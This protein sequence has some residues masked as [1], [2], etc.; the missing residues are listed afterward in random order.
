MDQ[1]RTATLRDG[2]LAPFGD[3]D[4]NEP[5]D[6]TWSERDGDDRFEVGPDDDEFDD[7]DDDDE[8]DGPADRGGATRAAVAADL[9][10]VLTA[11]AALAAQLGAPC[12]RCAAGQYHS[13]LDHYAAQRRQVHTH[14]GAGRAGA[15]GG[16]A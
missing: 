3:P 7:G 8:L 2:D 1:A 6:W 13:D 12:Q 16:A 9:R 4:D 10:W 14:A 11:S 15:Q 5:D